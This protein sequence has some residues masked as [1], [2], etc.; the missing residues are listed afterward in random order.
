MIRRLEYEIVPFAIDEPLSKLHDTLFKFLRNEYLMTQSGKRKV[1]VIGEFKFC[2]AFRLGERIPY[3][4]EVGHK[5]LGEI[6]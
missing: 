1:E 4:R 2:Q 3:L 5:S 6:G